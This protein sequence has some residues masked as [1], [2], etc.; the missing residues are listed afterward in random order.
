M[1]HS[2]QC[3]KCQSR[4]VGYLEYQT[5]KIGGVA[6]PRSVGHRVE[7]QEIAIAMSDAGDLEAYVCVACGYFESF[8]KEPASVPWDQLA[9]FRWVNDD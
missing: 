3:P 7:Q 5:D 4:K 2:K 6:G 9:G 1:K 8:V